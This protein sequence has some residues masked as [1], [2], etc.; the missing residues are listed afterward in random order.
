M[1]T[2]PVDL[3]ERIATA[4][5]MLSTMNVT[6][7][8][9]RLEELDEEQRRHMLMEILAQAM[10]NVGTHPNWSFKATVLDQHMSVVS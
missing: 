10:L 6:E 7:M 5:H 4:Q 8:S 2:M 3:A 9:A 1:D